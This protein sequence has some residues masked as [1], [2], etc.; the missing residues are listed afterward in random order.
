MVNFSESLISLGPSDEARAA[1]HKSPRPA[2][3]FPELPNI[4][5]TWE[6]D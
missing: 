3:P 2:F 6:F 4:L 5:E 1:A